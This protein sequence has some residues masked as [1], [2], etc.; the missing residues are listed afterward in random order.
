M[1]VEMERV[2]FWMVDGKVYVGKCLEKEGGIIGTTYVAF[3][4]ESDL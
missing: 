3:A 4:C 2:C 1:I